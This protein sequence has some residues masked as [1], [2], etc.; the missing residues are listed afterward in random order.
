MVE[1][2]TGRLSTKAKVNLWENHRLAGIVPRLTGH[3][4]EV[5]AVRYNIYVQP[6]VLNEVDI[7]QV[8]FFFKCQMLGD[9]KRSSV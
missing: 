3:L 7:I 9:V 4:L 8:L 6:F 2:Y 5:T 1:D